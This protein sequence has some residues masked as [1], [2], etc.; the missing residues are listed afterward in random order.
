MDPQAF[1]SWRSWILTGNRGTAADRRRVRGAHRGLK[2]MLAE[3]MTK[4]ET[5]RPWNEFSGA[6]VRQA[7]NEAVNQLPVEDMVM[8]KMAFFGGLSNREIAGRLNLR[9]GAV[10]RRLAKALDHISEHLE[11]GRELGRRAAYAILGW[12][13]ARSIVQAAHRLSAL[14]TEH[15]ACALVVAAVAAS[16]TIQPAVASPAPSS[17]RSST[18]AAPSAPATAGSAAS[19]AS[20]APVAAPAISTPS[21]S[22]PSVSSPS[23]SVP[24]VPGLVPKVTRLVKLPAVP[25]GQPSL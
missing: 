15:L 13:A 2:K 24:L 6:M 16:I 3:G 1:D 7:V 25:L 4:R 11:R 21:I 18:R 20:A 14:G 12:L 22:P 8:V 10:Q 17:A 9:P 19:P 23:V 5:A